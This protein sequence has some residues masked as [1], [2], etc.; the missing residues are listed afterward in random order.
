M[1]LRAL[2]DF[3]LHPQATAVNFDEMLGDGEP[4]PGAA[5]FAR[6]RDVHT[7]EALKNARL[8]GLRDADTG[9]GNRKSYF[10]V[11]GRGADHDLTAR[12]GVLQGVVQEILQNLGETAAVRSDVRDILRQIDGN[13][14]ILFSGGT[15]GSFDTAFDKLGNTQAANLQLQ[16]VGIHFRKL[17]QVI[18]EPS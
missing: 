18:G 12:R 16:A 13:A 4:Q 7:V 1:K 8:V 11:V 17:K 14:Q 3:A 6:A 9:V 15:L 10:A 5:D 2:A